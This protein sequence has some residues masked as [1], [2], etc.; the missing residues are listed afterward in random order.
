M[1]CNTTEQRNKHNDIRVYKYFTGLALA[2]LLVPGYSLLGQ[3]FDKY[4]P[5]AG[6]VCEACGALGII[7]FPPLAQILLDNYGW[8]NTL[9]LLGGIYSHMIIGG[10]LF[11]TPSHM[12]KYSLLPTSD[13]LDDNNSSLK[14]NDSEYETFKAFTW[15][16]L[17]STGSVQTSKRKFKILYS[18]GLHLFKNLS[19]L[20]NCAAYSSTAGVYTGWIIYFVP[21]CLTKGLTLQEASL[22]ASIAGFAYLLGSFVYIP[23]V[24]KRLI[25]VRGYIYISC[26][27]ASISFFA[28]TFSS[29]F[30]T[31]LLSSTAFTFSKSA[32]HPLLDVCLKSVTDED[33]FSKAFG[34]RVAVVGV[35]RVL[36]G[37]LV[38]KCF[39]HGR[40]KF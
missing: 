9:L 4:Y 33:D 10:I 26:F 24:T 7:V 37:F 34:W 39:F 3:Y 12:Q 2:L 6:G 14:T 16:D 25:S 23:I 8:R 29:T 15:K 40:S 1:T 36:S 27:V 20:A 19:F 17:P 30:T 28:D 5:L 11:R 22:L 18:T 35:F 38:G 32:V 13:Y 21:H 31:V